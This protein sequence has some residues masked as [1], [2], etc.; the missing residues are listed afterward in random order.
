MW[1]KKKKMQVTI[2]FFSE[3]FQSF[4]LK[5]DKTWGVRGK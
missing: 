3:V 1:E 4:S 2:I 5:V